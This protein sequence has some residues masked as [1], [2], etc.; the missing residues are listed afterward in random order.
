MPDLLDRLDTI[1]R[2]FVRED[3]AGVSDVEFIKRVYERF[4]KSR[5]QDLLDPAE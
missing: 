1:L 4:M 3:D 2:R 5:E